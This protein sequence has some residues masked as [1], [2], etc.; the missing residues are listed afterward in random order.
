M[1]KNHKLWERLNEDYP[2]VP[3]KLMEK[4]PNVVERIK[5]EFH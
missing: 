4:H 2:H 5:A 3:E 1:A